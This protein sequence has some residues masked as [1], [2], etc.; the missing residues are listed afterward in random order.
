MKLKFTLLALALAW[1]G[2]DGVRAEEPKEPTVAE[3]KAEV[4]K[5]QAEKERMEALLNAAWERYQKCDATLFQLQ[6]QA[7]KDTKARPKVP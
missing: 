2:R 1:F 4:A 7:S 3:L 5:L 6:V